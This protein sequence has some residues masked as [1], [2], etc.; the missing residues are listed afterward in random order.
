MIK[1]F[2]SF[3]NESKKETN[4]VFYGHKNVNKDGGEYF[5]AI[6]CKSIRY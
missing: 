6:Y 2:N 5:N 3:L 1:E 4:L